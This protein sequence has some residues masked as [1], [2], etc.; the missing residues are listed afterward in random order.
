M[1][2]RFALTDPVHIASRYDLMPLFDVKESFNIAPSM[3]LPIIRLE[4]ELPSL[5]GED[6]D[7]ARA[8]ARGR[9]IVSAKWGLVPGWSKEPESKYKLINLRSETIA[10]KPYFHRL[11]E[12]KRCLVPANGFFEWHA[13][14]SGKVPYYIYLKDRS[15]FSFAGVWDDWHSKL[16]TFSIITCDS[17]ELVSEIHDRM[18]VILPREYEADWLDVRR[19]IDPRELLKPYPADEM[20][21]HEVSRLVNSPKNDSRELI[22][23]VS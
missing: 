4:A 8:K 10:D 11:L 14:P 12:S 19:E 2:G 16:T 5:P 17:N 9:E 15:M 3:F 18:P 7:D 21:M 22:Q 23:P 6:H 13:T 1:C 20:A